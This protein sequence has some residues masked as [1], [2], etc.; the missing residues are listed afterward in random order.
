MKKTIEEVREKFLQK[1]LYL[2]DT[3]YKNNR[4]KM[5]CHDDKGYYYS[6]SFNSVSDQ[7][8]ES[9]KIV[10]RTNEYSIQNIQNYINKHGYNTKVL[11]DKYIGEKG[12]IQCKCECGEIFSTHWNHIHNSNKFT[13][14]KCG[15]KR[16]TE[17]QTYSIQYVKDRIKEYGYDLLED[18]YVDSHNFSIQGKDGYRYKTSYYNIV[19]EMTN[20]DKFDKLNPYTIYNMNLYIRLNDLSIE[21]VDKTER[22]IEVRK[23]YLEFYCI[24]CRDIFK[25]TWNQIIFNKRYR[26][27]KCCKRESNNEYYVRK[28]LEDKGVEFIQEKRFSDCVNIKPL[29]FDFYIPSINYV[30]E[31]HGQ[32]HYYENDMFDQSLEDRKNIDEIKKD[33]CKNN[34]IGYLEIPY[35]LITQSK[36][37][38]YKSMID[39]ILKKD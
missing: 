9:F 3:T 13:C 31:V 34:G 17:L 1:E 7:R 29:P 24:D 36:V 20:F 28:Y 18:T 15:I 38:T 23:D 19:N 12:I 4:T 21:M 11:S 37:A 16:R 14:T 8:T 22:Q 25:A 33:Y 32:Q 6:L 35:W 26:C 39:K 5:K 30:I 27:K 2:D 10:S